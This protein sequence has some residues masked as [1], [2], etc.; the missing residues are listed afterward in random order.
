MAEQLHRQARLADAVQIDTGQ[1]NEAMSRANLRGAR[2]RAWETRR[3]KYGPKGHAAG[4]YRARGPIGAV[5]VVLR[6][7]ID[8]LSLARR[9]CQLVLFLSDYK[10]QAMHSAIDKIDNAW[11][12]LEAL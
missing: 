6:T 2:Y 7:A 1:A 5:R 4:T 9:Q 12:I 8:E 10:S 11:R 3:A